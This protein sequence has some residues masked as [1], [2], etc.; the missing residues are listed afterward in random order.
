MTIEVGALKYNQIPKLR[1]L[2]ARHINALD[3]KL[4]E[5][6]IKMG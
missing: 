2:G 4:L 1:D 3:V 6:Y 5:P